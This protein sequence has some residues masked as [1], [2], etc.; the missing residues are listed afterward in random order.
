MR[1]RERLDELHYDYIGG[2]VTGLET[3][4][5]LIVDILESLIK[6]ADDQRY[7]SHRIT[8]DDEADNV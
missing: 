7:H 1:L 5:H 8:I 6:D 3:E 2:D 4:I